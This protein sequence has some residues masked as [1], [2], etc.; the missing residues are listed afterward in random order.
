MP[1]RSDRDILE[2]RQKGRTLAAELGFTSTGLTM[3]A[4]AIS[5]LARNIVLYARRGEIVLARID[6]DGRQ[7]VV[8]VARDE[9]PGIPDINLAMQSGYST[10]GSLGLG[11]PGVRRIMDEFSIVSEVGKGTSVTAK[12]W[13][14]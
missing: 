13:K 9:G 1:I 11:L 5:E 6:E 2:A 12:K 3:V 14:P 8:V 7:G 10:S 4:T